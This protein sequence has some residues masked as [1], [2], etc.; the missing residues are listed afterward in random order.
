MEKKLISNRALVFRIVSVVLLFS[1]M[2][3]FVSTEYLKKTAVDTLAS[4]DAQ[5]TAQLVFETMNTR[6]QEGWTKE[7]LDGIIGRLEVIRKGMSI[8]SYRSEKVE[9]LF[10]VVKRDKKI[11]DSDPLIQKAML[12]EEIFFVDDKSGMVRFLYPMKTNTECSHCHINAKDGDVNGVLD[13]SFPHS[14][15]KI[16]LDKMSIYFMI[17]FVI[18]LIVFSILF[19]TI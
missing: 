5:K 7:D 6:M 1:V 11:V 12:G 18:F 3:L 9:E 4:D 8:A 10:G 2:V 15:I 17:F 16:S 14:D 13:I 19:F